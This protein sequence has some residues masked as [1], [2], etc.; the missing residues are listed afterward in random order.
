VS[1]EDVI[2]ELVADNPQMRLV[3][4][5]AL[6]ATL[7]FLRQWLPGEQAGPPPWGPITR[8]YM[9]KV[10]PRLIVVLDGGRSFGPEALSEARRLGVPVAVIGEPALHNGLQEAAPAHLVF[11]GPD[12]SPEHVVKTLRPLVPSANRAPVDNAWLTGTLRDRIGQ[13]RLWRSVSRLLTR[14]RID[15]WEAL[16]QRLDHPRTVLCL[17]NGPSSEDPRLERLPHDCLI[18]VNWRW[19]D[20]GLLAHPQIVFVGD[21]ATMHRAPSCIY[22]F[23]NGSIESAMLLRHL[24]VRGPSRME[25]I[26]TE[27]LSP[28]VRD[29]AWPARPSNG[30]LMIVTAAGLAPE[31]LIISGIDLFQH[32]AGPYPGGSVA[33]N[34][35]SRVHSRDVELALIDLALRNY[36]GEVVILS[37]ILRDSLTQYRET[38]NG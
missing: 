34:K 32:P 15:D 12:Q 21:A 22:G 26:T 8:R 2:S 10:N 7:T 17:G 4:T 16:R 3:L 5:S 27:R 24:M 31:R 18:R 38:R 9:S 36:Q 28:L 11:R 19:R 30:A 13:S 6:P 35:Y 29:R 14:R 25:Y 23:W 20:R 33:A 37:D 1:A